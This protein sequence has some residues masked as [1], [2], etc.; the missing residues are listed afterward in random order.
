MS[1]VV[2][3]AVGVALFPAGIGVAGFRALKGVPGRWEL[4]KCSRLSGWGSRPGVP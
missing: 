3:V 4:A 2:V 1:K